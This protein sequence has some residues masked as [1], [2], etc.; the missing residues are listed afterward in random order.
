MHPNSLVIH[1]FT[2]LRVG[3]LPK[4]KKKSP[5]LKFPRENSAPSAEAG[6][7][8]RG[9]PDGASPAHTPDALPLTSP[10]RSLTAILR[11]GTRCFKTKGQ[12]KNSSGG[13]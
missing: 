5:N 12:F 11:A 9:Y 13:S 1:A 2:A 8:S 10:G 4:K 7:A 3:T 6:D